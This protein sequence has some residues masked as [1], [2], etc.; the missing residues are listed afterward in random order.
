MIKVSILNH[1][2]ICQYDACTV[3][4]KKNEWKG[5]IRGVNVD[6]FCVLGRLSGFG[7]RIFFGF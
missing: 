2:S 3:S 4:S 1:S 5:S 6:F 7:Y